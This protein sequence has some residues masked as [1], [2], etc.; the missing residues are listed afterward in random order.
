MHGGD[1]RL[2]RRSVSTGPVSGARLGFLVREAVWQARLWI[3]S[4]GAD[5]FWAACRRSGLPRFAR[6]D[7]SGRVLWIAWARKGLPRFARNAAT[8]EDVLPGAPTFYWAI[9]LCASLTGCTPRTVNQ[10]PTKQ[11]STDPASAFEDIT[12]RSGVRFQH[13][14][15]ATGKKW[16]PETMGSGCALVDVDNDGR[17]DVFLVDSGAW[18]G[19]GGPAGQSRLFRNLGQGRFQDVTSQY[20]IPPGLYGMGVAGGDFDNDGYTDLF[21]TALNGSRLLRNLAGKR[22]ED[23][24]ARVRLGVQGWPTSAAWLDYN[25]DGKLDLFVCRYVRWTPALDESLFVSLDGSHKSYARPDNFPG[26]TCRLFRNDGGRFTDVS[27]AAGVNKPGAKALGVALCDF[28]G[29]GWTDLAVSNDTVPNFLL[30]NQGNGSFKEVA[31]QAGIAVAEAGTAK[32]GMGIDVADYENQGQPGILITNFAGEQLSLY[33]R[34]PSGLFMDVAARAGIGIPSQRYLGFG[35]FFFDADL[36]GWQDILVANGHIQDDIAVRNAGVGYAQPALLFRGVG[37]GQFEDVSRTAGALTVRRVA[38]GAA[39]GDL[40]GDGDLDLLITTNAG[41]ATL[42]RQ[43]GPPRFHWLSVRLEGRGSNRSAIG[44]TIRVRSDDLVQTRMVRSGSSY[45]SQSSLE[46]TF[47]L[48][49][50]TSVKEIEVR[51]PNGNVESFPCPGV[52]RSL[53]LVEGAGR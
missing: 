40:D 27:A 46:A 53:H 8:F 31:V 21:V 41:P 17:L 38:R 37:G 34:D 3:C 2:R 7:S 48:G 51:W 47:G 13:H 29:D 14:N 25:R 22:F 6:N 18:P 24:T 39:Y 10:A 15:G 20:R 52:D 36:D 50:H 49:K 33:H 30:H 44:A 23:V 4:H 32:A 28:D 35:A 42:L 16:M 19:S 5:E 1:D 11:S 12:A 26:D 9:L 43:A 45:L